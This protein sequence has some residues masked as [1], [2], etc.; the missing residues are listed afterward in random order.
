MWFEDELEDSGTGPKVE[1][2]SAHDEQLKLSER[3][4]FD[5]P[6]VREQAIQAPNSGRL[7]NSNAPQS[8]KDVSMS[9][10]K[11]Q[12]P[13]LNLPSVSEL[14]SSF[15]R[16]KIPQE[17]DFKHLIDMATVGCSAIGLAP[18]NTTAQPGTGLSVI[19]GKL[20]AWVIPVGTIVMFSPPA[21]NQGKIPDGWA[22]CDGSKGTP[23]LRNRFIMGG[24]LVD[25]KKG[26]QSVFS[27]APSEKCFTA[28]TDMVQVISRIHIEGCALSLEQIPSHQHN[29]QIRYEEG[30][31][32]AS[33]F[34]Y[35]RSK[36]QGNLGVLDPKI[37]GEHYGHYD[38]E[39]TT[40]V[41]GDGGITQ[42]HTHDNY[43]ETEKHQHAIKITP[44]YM[45]LAFIMK[46]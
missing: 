32:G 9:N 30:N 33:S 23:D 10:V 37:V 31:L 8:I 5:E 27:G 24:E 28:T 46:I 6:Q 20:H 12:F 4:Y 16:G 2:Q 29:G 36:T 14:K 25:C 3:R 35:V 11:S 43:L 22:L 44:P 19:D 41:G 15:G 34:E 42:E 7:I 38:V 17:A 39:K 21:D 45:I 18:G 26:T 40:K 13:D 1:S